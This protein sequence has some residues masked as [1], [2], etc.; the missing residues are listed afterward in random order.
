MNINDHETKRGA[1]YRIMFLDRE[2]MHSIIDADGIQDT[3]QLI[4]GGTYSA[5][6]E[7]YVAMNSEPYYWDFVILGEHSPLVQVRIM[8]K[9]VQ[10][11][12][13]HLKWV[14]HG[15]PRYLTPKEL[16]DLKANDKPMIGG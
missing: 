14:H 7:N 10:A 12:K 2:L 3:Q 4:L 6:L 16:E 1:F 15:T 8:Y 9:D 13:V 5:I 11:E